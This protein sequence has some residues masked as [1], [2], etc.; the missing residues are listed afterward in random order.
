MD[1]INFFL[2]YTGKPPYDENAPAEVLSTFQQAVLGLLVDYDEDLKLKPSLLES[3]YWDFK[4]SKYILTLKDNIYFHNGRRATSADLEY[5]LIRGFFSKNKSFY[6]IYLNNIVGVDKVK[7][8]DKFESGIIEGIKIESDRSV[9]VKITNFNPTW[10]YVL[11]RPYFSL[12]PREALQSN[13]LLWKDLPVGAG[14]Y[15]IKT[16]YANGSIEIEKI[17]KN[18]NGPSHVILH[19]EYN[20]KIKYDLSLKELP[21]RNTYEV[22]QS[23]YPLVIWGIFFNNVNDLGSNKDF[24][25]AVM[26]A[27]DRTEI[28]AGDSS[29]KPAYEPLTSLI[30]GRNNTKY[31]PDLKKSL[32]YIEKIKNYPKNEKIKIPVFSGTKI[33]ESRQKKLDIISKQLKM[34][35][36]NVEFFATSEKFIS[37]DVAKSSPFIIS[38]RVANMLDPLLMFASYRKNSPYEFESPKDD[39]AF[40]NLYTH[41]LNTK[42]EK[43]RLKAIQN[44][45]KHVTDEAIMIPMLEIKS[46]FF[47]QEKSIKSIG[48]QFKA[49][50]LDLSKV[51]LND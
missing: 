1:K 13:N 51:I 50:T 15:K 31:N 41:A 27:I 42:D 8:T 23:K 17:D 5:S 7:P 28:I 14:P 2:G 26:Y 45:S 46:E 6:Q 38:G 33:T 34:I 39:S 40:E 11:T 24:K 16:P 49:Q 20:E 32:S 30:W 4:S 43:P 22:L 35:G 48:N 19:T 44:L 10:I 37:R 36:L 12:V 25:K 21:D 3:W 18:V 9:S 29:A 47:Y